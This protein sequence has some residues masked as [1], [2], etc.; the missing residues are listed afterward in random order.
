MKSIKKNK[1][2]LRF[3]IH[4]IFIFIFLY[5]I[6]LSKQ[7]SIIHETSEATLKKNI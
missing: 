7:A 4:S 5:A 3:K 1:D 2:L 6:I